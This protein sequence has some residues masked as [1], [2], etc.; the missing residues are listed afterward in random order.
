MPLELRYRERNEARPRG[1]EENEDRQGKRVRMSDGKGREGEVEEER[2]RG[3]MCN[4]LIYA[5]CES[6]PADA[7]RPHNVADSDPGAG[8][9]AN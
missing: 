9:G 6:G 8:A 5:N 4:R 2:G 7:A 1:R 3:S